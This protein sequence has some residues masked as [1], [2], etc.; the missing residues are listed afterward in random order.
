MAHINVWHI[1]QFTPPPTRNE[2]KK[3]A[4]ETD[5]CE[6][7]LIVTDLYDIAVND[8]DAKKSARYSWEFI[9]TKLEGNGSQYA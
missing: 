6:W 4:K 9:V 1:E 8:F 5:R 2:K 3:H 7:L